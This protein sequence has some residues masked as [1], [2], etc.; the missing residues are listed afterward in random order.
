MYV[1]C[2]CST[3]CMY[4]VYVVLCVCTVCMYCVYVLYVCTICMYCMYVLYIC[5]D[6]QEEIKKANKQTDRT[7]KKGKRW[8]G[9]LGATINR[10]R[11]AS[12]IAKNKP[13]RKTTIKR[14][15]TPPPRIPR[16]KLKASHIYTPNLVQ[17]LSPNQV[18]TLGEKEEKKD[19]A[20]GIQEQ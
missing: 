4:C 2:V 7:L 6:E 14:T 5:V 13:Q 11:Y 8:K 9:M 10:I 15:I 19:G 16:C 3:V 20:T 17:T 18:N 12:Y 1:L